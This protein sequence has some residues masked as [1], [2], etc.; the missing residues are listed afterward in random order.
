METT[1]RKAGLGP[2]QSPESQQK[3][4]EVVHGDPEATAQVSRNLESTQERKEFLGCK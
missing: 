2:G 1:K 4:L 3:R